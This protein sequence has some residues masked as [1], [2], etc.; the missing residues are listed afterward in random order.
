MKSLQR[1]LL[2]LGAICVAGS[3]VISCSKGGSSPSTGTNPTPTPTPSPTDPCASKNLAVSGTTTASDACGS[4]TI[5]ITATGSS[6][7][8]YSIDGGSFQASNSFTKVTPGDHTITAKDGEG[9]SKSGSVNVPASQSGPLFAAVKSMMAN[10]CLSCHSAGNLQGGMDWSKDC[11]IITNSARIK[12][13]AV[14]GSPSFMP[15]GG[16]LSAS[17]KKKITDW[18]NAGGRYSD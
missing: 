12:A 4:G 18:I 10:N 16:E 7:F 1:P 17:D 14:D 9:C 11:N 8:T 2:I 5:T 13:R 3:L 15:Q 6:N